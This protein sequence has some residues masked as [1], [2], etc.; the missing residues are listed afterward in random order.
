MTEWVTWI[1]FLTSAAI[2]AGILAAEVRH[3]VRHRRGRS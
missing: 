2:A 1:P 3:Q